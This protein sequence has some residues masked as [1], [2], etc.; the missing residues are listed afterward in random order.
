MSSISFRLRNRIYGIY[1]LWRVRTLV[2][3]IGSLLSRLCGVTGIAR[4]RPG[5]TRPA[6]GPGHL[7]PGRS[8]PLPRALSQQQHPGAGT[9]GKAFPPGLE[10]VDN[11][12]SC[13]PHGRPLFFVESLPVEP[14]PRHTLEGGRERAGKPPPRPQVRPRGAA[15]SRTRR[16]SVG[17]NTGPQAAQKACRSRARGFW[18]P[19]PHPVAACA[20]RGRSRGFP[21]CRL[22]Q[23]TPSRGPGADAPSRR[24]RAARVVALG[25]DRK[26]VCSSAEPWLESPNGPR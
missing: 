9:G 14:G 23:W 11:S 26:R 1:G 8:R 21:L 5:R 16:Q 17:R 3:Q 18:L 15:R 13:P 12:A 24:A 19:T 20:S 25:D 6:S 2:S 10:G 4:L 22:H 7:Q